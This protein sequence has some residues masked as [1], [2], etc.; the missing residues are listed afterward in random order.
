MPQ[1]GLGLAPLPRAFLIE[2]SCEN[3][4]SNACKSEAAARGSVAL[5]VGWP[6]RRR[7]EVYAGSTSPTRRP[8]RFTLPDGLNRGAR[9]TCRQHAK[10]RKSGCP[11][12]LYGLWRRSREPLMCGYFA[13]EVCGR[14]SISFGRP[15]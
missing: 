10:H 4:L 6:C 11:S 2:L 12:N 9:D 3:V 14:A 5:P 7:E 1:A 8:T 15:A 13:Q